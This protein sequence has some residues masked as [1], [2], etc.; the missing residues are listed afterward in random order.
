MSC[1]LLPIVY[2]PAATCEDWEKQI[3]ETF[4]PDAVDSGLAWQTLALLM[5]PFTALQKALLLL[6]PGGTGKSTFLT[7]TG[8]FLG[9]RNIA[10]LTLQK[11]EMDRFAVARL[12]GKLANICADL[13]STHLETSSMFKSITGGDLITGE[14][15]FFDSFDFV[16]FARLIFS[17]NQPPRSKDASDAFLGRWWVVPFECVWHGTEQEIPRRT[18]DAKLP[19]P[20]QLSGAL[21]QALDHIEEVLDHG[22]TETESMRKAR[23]EFQRATDPFS[24][25]LRVKTV[26]HPQAVVPKADL[27]G[28]YA[29]YCEDA[30]HPM[31]TDTAF[32]LTLKKLRPNVTD[33][34]RTVNNRLQWCYVGIG[35]REQE[36]ARQ[37]QEAH[38]EEQAIRESWRHN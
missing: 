13:P 23:E 7:A 37:Q 22:L 34:Q 16:P 15:K 24:V 19:D 2:D 30:G 33:A 29:T 9:R 32:G 35:L 3:K 1:V 11:L 8:A 6:G 14:Y 25:Y 17:A 20:R 12:V 21:N 5:V 38:D 26:E 28:H 10:S 31:M 18:L 36:N 27:R 4:P